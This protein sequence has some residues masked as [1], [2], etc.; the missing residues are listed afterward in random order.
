MRREVTRA[1]SSRDWERHDLAFGGQTSDSALLRLTTQAHP[2]THLLQHSR[3]CDTTGHAVSV[4]LPAPIKR[5]RSDV[6][7][8]RLRPLV[9]VRGHRARLHLPRREHGPDRRRS[10]DAAAC[11]RELGQGD[12]D[13]LLEARKARMDV[14]V[15][16]AR[17]ISL[18]EFR[19]FAGNALSRVRLRGSH[20][21]HKEYE[22]E[23][24][25]LGGRT[26][27]GFSIQVVFYEVR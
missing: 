5:A 15:R 7:L 1:A 8:L 3:R 9:V 27:K 16:L 13:D 20:Q 21:Y 12:I 25:A 23:S 11:A 18:A 26:M 17:C 22:R 14:L 19:D 4:P 2:G 6:A 10:R 24:R